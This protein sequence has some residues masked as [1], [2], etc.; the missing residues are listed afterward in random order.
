MLEAEGGHHECGVRTVNLLLLT[1]FCTPEPIFKSVPF[2]K[3]LRSRGHDARI[4]T[5]FPNYP[6]GEL[7]PDYRIRLFAREFIE[8]VPI[9]RVPLYPSHDRSTANRFLNYVSFAASAAIPLLFGWKPDVIHVNSLPTKGIVA[10]L[11]SCLTKVPYVMDVQDLWPDAVINSGMVP[12]RL[13]FLLH[14]L[15]RFAYRGAASICCLS[16]GMRLALS[17]RGISA[18]RLEVI[19]NWCD[20]SK[21]S[22][23]SEDVPSQTAL[24]LANR[25]NIMFAG[26]MSKAQGLSAVIDAA[27]IVA[28]TNPRVQF[29]FIGSGRMVEELKK[30]A[31]AAAPGNTLFLPQCPLGRAGQLIRMADVMLVHLRKDPLY[32][33]TIPSK[34]Q[35]YM[36]LAKPILIGVPGDAE[37]LV[38][39][40][41][42]GLAV[43]PENPV[44]IADATLLLSRKPKRALDLMGEA[45]KKFYEENLSLRVGVTKFERLFRRV[46]CSVHTKVNEGKGT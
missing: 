9:L 2:A 43:E 4:L 25:F 44:A 33:L 22:H 21:L 40:A 14:L 15:S 12:R 35:A 38:L 26:T 18:D 32:H 13:Q 36:A 19:Y 8:G 17:R 30:K 7:Y 23:C 5:G 37:D 45:G 11:S 16:P 1:Q 28:K 27:A 24:G 3:E 10:R 31:A 46:N 6:G 34:T 29:V 20:E 39:R 42:A 41:K